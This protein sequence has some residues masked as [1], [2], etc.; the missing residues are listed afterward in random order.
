MI[1]II[2]AVIA[3]DNTVP[4]QLVLDEGQDE[5]YDALVWGDSS[6]VIS[7]DLVETKWAELKSAEPSNE[8]KTE[9]KKRIAAT[10]WSVLPDVGI[11]NTTEF[12]TY[13]ATLRGLIK[14]PVADPVWP[15]EPEPVWS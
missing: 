2:E 9:A 5:N 12:E 11:S 14:N 13:R 1:S 7:R 15:T 10:D 6:N 3:I 4:V 8:C